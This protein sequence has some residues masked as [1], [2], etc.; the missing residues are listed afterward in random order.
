MELWKLIVSYYSDLDFYN[1]EFSDPMRLFYFVG[2]FA[3]GGVAS[4]IAAYVSKRRTGKIVDPLLGIHAHDEATAIT[5]EEGKFDK[6][7]L[8][9]LLKR[10]SMLRRTVQATDP[11]QSEDEGEAVAPTK[12]AIIGCLR[13]MRFYIPDERR[14]EAERR[15]SAKRNGILTLAFSIAV[16]ILLTVLVY[17][18]L[19]IVLRMVDNFLNM[20]GGNI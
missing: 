6:P 10:G 17:L 11:E 19:P 3:V 13:R 1:L 9:I 7:S 16:V 8:L 15:Y 5:P 12:S 2:A 14:S 18:F 20:T 4:V